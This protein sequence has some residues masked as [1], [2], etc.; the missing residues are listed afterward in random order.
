MSVLSQKQKLPFKKIAFSL[1]AFNFNRVPEIQLHL[2][3]LAAEY[4]PH[5][6]TF[7]NGSTEETLYIRRSI[8]LSIDHKIA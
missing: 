8:G 6:S 5:V 2:Y 7:S 4:V 3:I 1:Q